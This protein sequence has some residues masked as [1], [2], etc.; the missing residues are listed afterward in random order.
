MDE[1]EQSVMATFNF[2]SS[3]QTDSDISSTT[4]DIA[5]PRT[6]VTG[7]YVR[8]LITATARAANPFLDVTTTAN[9]NRNH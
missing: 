2:L 4:A 7:L 3:E 1:E 6:E 5:L 9:N 8:E